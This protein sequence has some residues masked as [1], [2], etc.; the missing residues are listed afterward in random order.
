METLRKAWLGMKQETKVIF[1]IISLVFSVI[2]FVGILIYAHHWNEKKHLVTEVID[3][4]VTISADFKISKLT[5]D[6][7]AV[8]ATGGTFLV[9]GIFQAIKG[10]Q[11]NIEVRGNGSKKLCDT[12]QDICFELI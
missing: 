7:T 9:A 8:S 1:Y 4:G 6:T 2:L 3:V 12:V 5:G 11:L 10:N